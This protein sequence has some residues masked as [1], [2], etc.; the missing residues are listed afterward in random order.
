MAKAAPKITGVLYRHG[1][2][3][4]ALKALGSELAKA[5]VVP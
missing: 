4:H 1:P 3:S 2:E 5:G